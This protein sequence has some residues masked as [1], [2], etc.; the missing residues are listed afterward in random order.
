ME[1]VET[2]EKLNA[3]QAGKCKVEN[4]EALY[5]YGGNKPESNGFRLGFNY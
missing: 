1:S 3:S 4:R 2:I 5:L